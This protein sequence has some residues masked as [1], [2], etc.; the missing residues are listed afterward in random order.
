RAVQEGRDLGARRCDGDAVSGAGLDVRSEAAEP[1]S[2]CGLIPTVEKS[3]V[4][5]PTVMPGLDPGIP[6]GTGIAKEAVTS[7]NGAYG[8][9]RVKPGHDGWGRSAPGTSILSVP[10][11]T[12]TR[13]ATLIERRRQYRL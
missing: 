9:G 6:T 5:S 4:H 7:C 13:L 8:D 11:I 1:G 2:R 12:P 10:G 3:D